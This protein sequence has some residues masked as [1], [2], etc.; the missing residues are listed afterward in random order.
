MDKKIASIKHVDLCSISVARFE[1][2]S[3]IFCYQSHFCYENG[4]RI[5][6]L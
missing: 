5:P 4:V 2:I 3:F 1:G 6:M